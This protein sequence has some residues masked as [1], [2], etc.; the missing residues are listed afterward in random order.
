[1]VIAASP[2]SFTLTGDVQEIQA[3]TFV[4]PVPVPA[5]ALVIFRCLFELVFGQVDEIAA[6]VRV[7]VQR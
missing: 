6:E 3:C 7:I 4:I 2:S 1:M 5:L